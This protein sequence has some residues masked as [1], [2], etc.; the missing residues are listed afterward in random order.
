MSEHAFGVVG[1]ETLHDG[2][3]V[4]L[5]VDQVQMPG[6]R[7]AGREVVEH[8]AAVAVLALDAGDRV[9]LL[10]QYRHPVATRLWELPAGM[11]D[12]DGEAPLSAAQR[13]L[14]EEAGLSASQWA[15]L[16]DVVSSPG[17]TDESVR[18]YLAT[19][20]GEVTAGTGIDDEEAEMTTRWV[21]LDDAV[22]QVL[23]GEIVDASTMA[24]LLALAAARASGTALRPVD[25]PWP[26]RSTAFDARQ[27]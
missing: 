9:L 25:A 5:R 22:R 12:V 27:G 7:V 24:G 2:A 10:R 3:V 1:S 13:E 8:R 23:T 11:L 14:A 26:L 19:N 6:G 15:L 4:A 18:V 20:L 16:V 21:G 17:F